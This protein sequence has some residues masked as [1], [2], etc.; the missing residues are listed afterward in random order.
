[1]NQYDGEHGQPLKNRRGMGGGG[2][3]MIGALFTIAIFISVTVGYMSFS[4]LLREDGGAESA[5]QF[6]WQRVPLEEDLSE[7]TAWYQDDNEG[8]DRWIN[9][10]EWLESGL[11]YFFEQT[12]VRPYLHI[13]TP[14]AS[15]KIREMTDEELFDYLENMYG[16]LFTDGA[17]AL[18]VISND[19]DG[20]R[21][22]SEYIGPQALLVMDDEAVGILYNCFDYYWENDTDKEILFSNSFRY[23]ADSIMWESMEL[24]QWE[25]PIEQTPDEFAKIEEWVSKIETWI[26]GLPSKLSV[27]NMSDTTKTSI[28][29][30]LLILIGSGLIAAALAWRK[31]QDEQERNR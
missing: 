24:E 31:R 25:E 20:D 8:E 14:E 5:E 16:E 28:A 10:A 21:R 9:D 22:Y 4:E 29:L 18:F 13:N 7:E 23:T 26:S 30:A 27:D 12:G 15:V 1:M 6:G 17:H 2:C 3:L 19:G 11:Q